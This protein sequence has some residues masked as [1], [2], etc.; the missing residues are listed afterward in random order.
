[1][2]VRLV[3]NKPKIIGLTGGISSG[4]ST[5]VKYLLKEN[6]LV[7]DSDLAV[8][9][10]W[11]DNQILKEEIKNRY[12]IDL[13]STNGK[14]ELAHILFC[15]KEVRTE[16]ESLIHP[17]VFKM[18]DDWI[19]ENNEQ[20]FLIIDM[21]LLFE[22]GYHEK[23]DEVILIYVPCRV[24]LKRLMLRD[25]LSKE[26]SMNRIKSQM[27]IDEKINYSTYVINNEGDFDSLY[28]QIDKLVRGLKD[29][30]KQ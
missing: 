15:N 8:K 26:D 11:K 24:Q 28:E 17:I 9:N 13:D 7:F 3:K 22:V 5:V 2:S 12:S 6:I 18:I 10:I 4:K 19:V 14:S 21:P 16:V 27:K 23:V 25:N 1:M 29:E 30:G 20:K